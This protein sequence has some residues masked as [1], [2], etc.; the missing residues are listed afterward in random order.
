MKPNPGLCLRLLA[1]ALLLAG[2]PNGVLAESLSGNGL[3]LFSSAK[4]YQEGDLLTVIIDEAAQG[5][6]SASTELNK[7]TQLGFTTGGAIG[8]VVPSASGGLNSKQSGGGNLARQGRMQATL[9]VR[10]EKVLTSGCLVIAGDQEISFDSGVQRI[11]VH[12]S[13]RPRD[14]SAGNE[15]YSSRIAD[16]KIEYLGRDALNEKARTGFLSRF[17]EWLWIF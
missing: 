6:Q 12:G 17:L 3:S 2:F 5:T 11:S 15:V 1:W 7:E 10:V 13:V 8:N 14:I 16:A 9:T 4:S